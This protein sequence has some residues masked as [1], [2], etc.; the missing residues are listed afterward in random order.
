MLMPH[1]FFL[2][3]VEFCRF[4]SATALLIALLSPIACAGELLRTTQY[5]T[6]YTQQ[7]LPNPPVESTRGAVVALLLACLAQLHLSLII[8]TN[9]YSPFALLALHQGAHTYSNGLFD[10]TRD[11]SDTTIK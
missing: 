1:G 7:P 3:A 5:S 4:K 6:K 11:S 2:A 8:H 10:M 9:T